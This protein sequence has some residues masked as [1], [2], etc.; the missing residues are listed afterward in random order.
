MPCNLTRRDVSRIVLDVIRGI[1]RDQTIVEAT[2][3]GP[4]GINNDPEFRATYFAPIRRAIEEN[5]ECRIQRF[6]VSD[7][8][9]AGTVGDIVNA[10]FGDVR[11]RAVRA[12]ALGVAA[13]KS[14]RRA[15]A[16]PSKA[17]KS[18]KPGKARKPSKISKASKTHKA[19]TKKR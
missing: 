8:Q 1:Q 19:K 11:S 10:A 6:K 16:G 13:K 18:R 14:S 4:Q 2:V 9:N 7:C 3:F 5:A 12:V 15:T 17:G